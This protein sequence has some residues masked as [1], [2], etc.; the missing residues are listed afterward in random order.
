MGAILLLLLSAGSC[1]GPAD[2]YVAA[3]KATFEAVAPAYRAYVTADPALDA[4]QKARRLAVLESWGLRIRHAEST[5]EI[6][7]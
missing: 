7:K 5:K 2:A 3:D 4:E 6:A 1:T